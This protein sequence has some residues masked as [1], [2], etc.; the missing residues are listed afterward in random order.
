VY[1]Q[2]DIL[3][4]VKEPPIPYRETIAQGT[5][6]KKRVDSRLYWGIQSTRKT[7]TA[8]PNKVGLFDQTLESIVKYFPT[9]R[10]D[11]TN[12]SVGD[13]PSAAAGRLN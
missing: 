7:S 12:F 3:Q 4:A 9:H 2:A 1:L 10:T 13:N 11:A 5:G 6:I 8:E